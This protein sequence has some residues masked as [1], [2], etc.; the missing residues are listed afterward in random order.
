V[1]ETI[2]ALRFFGIVALF[3]Y[4]VNMILTCK[5]RYLRFTPDDHVLPCAIISASRRKTS[6][7]RIQ[8]GPRG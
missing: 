7:T 1:L 6:L 5:V 4:A 8:S 2:E 3:L